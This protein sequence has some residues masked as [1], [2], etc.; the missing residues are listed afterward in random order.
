MQRSLDQF[1]DLMEEPSK[2]GKND[3]IAKKK[4]EIRS[5]WADS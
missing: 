3:S 2:T 1:E 4:L 5:D